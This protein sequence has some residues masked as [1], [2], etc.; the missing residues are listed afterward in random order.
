MARQNFAVY[1]VNGGAVSR[2]A[3]TRIDLPQLTICGEIVENWMVSTLG[4]M[5]LRPGTRN[6]GAIRNNLKPQF[7]RFVGTASTCSLLELT[8][9]TLR[10][11]NDDS[12]VTRQ[13]VGTV[14]VN[15]NFPSLAGWTTTVPSGGS[16]V[17]AGGGAV[18]QGNGIARSRLTQQIVVPTGSAGVEHGLRIVVR[19]GPV[20]LRVGTT[21]GGEEIVAATQLQSGT[22]SLAIVLAG[23]FFL[24]FSSM[25]RAGRIVDFVGF[26]L[27]GIME[28][29]TPWN[30]VEVGLVRYEQQGDV[31]FCASRNNRQQRIESRS[32]RSWSVVNYFPS[33]G[34]FR[35]MVRGSALIT[36]S[37]TSGGITLSA[38]TATFNVQQIGTLFE[39]THPGQ[40]ETATLTGNDQYTDPIRV[41]GVG[42]ARK[43]SLSVSGT[44]T[45]T[46]TVQQA[47]GAPE[48]WRDYGSGHVYTAPATDTIDDGFDNSIVFY[49]I[50]IKPGGYTS[51]G[52]VVSLNYPGGTTVGT[53]IIV[54]YT[55]PTLVNADVVTDLGSATGTSL[56]REGQWS[57]YRGWPRGVAFQDGRLIWLG[58]N[59]LFASVSDDFANFDDSIDGDSAPVVRSIATGPADGNLWVLR[60]F[61]LVVA[62]ATSITGIRSSSLDEPITQK[63]FTAREIDQQGAADIAPIA[64]AGRGVYVGRSTIDLF[65][66]SPASDI[67]DYVVAL[68]NRLNPDITRVGIVKVAIQRRPEPRIWCV[69]ADGTMAIV[70]N[71]R[72]EKVIAWQSWKT[73]GY[74]EECEIMP[75]IGQDDV[76][77]CVNR[78]LNG[79]W[80]RRMER[81]SYEIDTIGGV[82]NEIAD[83]GRTVTNGLPSSLL[84]GLGDFEGKTVAVWTPSRRGYRV[85]VSGGVCSIPEAVTSAWV[86]LPYQASFKSTK[87]AYAAD[88]GTALLQKK[89]IDRLGIAFDTTAR[90]GVTVGA[91]PNKLDGLPLVVRGA[92][93]DPNI[94]EDDIDEAPSPIGD[95][96]ETDS[97]FYINAKGPWPCRVKA[98]VASITTHDAR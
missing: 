81:C 83:C 85:D 92:E 41:T 97:R 79:A 3:L 7:L 61:R 82:I 77:L 39:L 1:S 11:W 70:T 59:L 28:V 2:L 74:V 72:D 37:G 15:G 84:T 60:L 36:P 55:S 38:N 45:G 87:L 96:W 35:A 69:L 12:L 22:H 30:A 88:L 10:V 32:R 94:V 18:I 98:I 89:R 29:P 31:L 17:A 47:V 50:G 5:G 23:T 6:N 27:A 44:F 51:G 63:D 65:E 95:A 56:W 19:N 4:W 14:V 64:V 73:D 20:E 24:D 57:P 49:R 46:V 42:D 91:D 8:A 58:K 48:G 52:A 13:A 66:I 86:G 26:E 67:S 34:P 90:M 9:N 25:D 75:N 71:N 21:S 78:Y 76:R 62:S 43:V 54:G 53:V 40:F 16:V 93:V 33:K 80:T 68:L